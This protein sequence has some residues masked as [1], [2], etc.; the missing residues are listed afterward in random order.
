MG[1]S[2]GLL[3]LPKK[4]IEVYDLTGRCFLC[5]FTGHFDIG[6]NQM[7]SATSSFS[8]FAKHVRITYALVQVGEIDPL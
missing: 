5:W 8:K 3:L 1:H 7:V 4:I 2:R 6:V